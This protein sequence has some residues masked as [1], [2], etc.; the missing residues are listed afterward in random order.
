MTA[1]IL[2]AILQTPEVFQVLSKLQR[3]LSM[4]LPKEMARISVRAELKT[5][6]NKPAHVND[7][8]RRLKV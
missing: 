6:R 3:N 2:C 1:N 7:H 8:F 4:L 5:H